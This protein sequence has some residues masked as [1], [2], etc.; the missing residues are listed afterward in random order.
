VDIEENAAAQRLVIEKNNGK[1]IIPTIVS[2]DGTFLAEPSNAD[3]AA[4]LGLKTQASRSHFNFIV[5]GGGPAGLTASFFSPA[6][7][8]RERNTGAFCSRITT[9]SASAR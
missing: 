1:R 8:R 6:V 7:F 3:L 2:K 9:D 5:I 4:K